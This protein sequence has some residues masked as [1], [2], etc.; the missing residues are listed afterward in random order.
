MKYMNWKYMNRQRVSLAAAWFVAALSV[1][2]SLAQVPFEAPVTGPTAAVVAPP[3]TAGPSA[4]PTSAPA[5]SAGTRTL[6]PAPAPDQAG[7]VVGQIPAPIKKEPALPSGPSRRLHIHLGTQR[8]S[9]AEGE[10]VVRAGPVSSGKRGYGTPAG[11]YWVLSKQ[12]HKVSS[13]YAG[14]DGR[15]ASMPYAIQF[16]SNYFIHQGRLPGYPASHGC[17]RLRGAD[18]QFLFSR[19]RPGDP[20]FITR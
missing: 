7:A 6:S 19:L 2:D 10:Q 4:A 8:F 9:Y 3:A 16:R 5:G 15:P 14:S 12:R 11:A 17:V 13:R 1:S 20:V 18:A